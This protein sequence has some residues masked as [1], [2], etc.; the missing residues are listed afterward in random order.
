MTKDEALDLALEALELSS[1]T[2]DSFGVQRKTQE[3][4]I[5]IKQA[6]ALDKKAQNA[7]ELGLDYEP[8]LKDNS[9]YRYDPPFAEPDYKA[10]WQQ[11][12]ERC[13]ELDKELSATDR[14]V[15]ILSDALAES[16]REVAAPVQEPVA[17]MFQ[18]EETGRTM[19][20]DAQQIE[21]GFEKGNPRLKKIEPLYTTPP[22]AQR[23]WVGLI[24]QERKDIWR[25]AIGWGDPSHDDIGL[26]IAIEA[27]LKEK[28]T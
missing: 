2:V 4:I 3:A 15:E 5:A 12:C 18:H 24:Q 11:M 13:D 16:R 8:A 10:L 28:N 6:R 1:V 25:E 23:Q 26:M 21:W 19:C 14:Q 7:R 22:A 9:N 20:V 27:K 17:W